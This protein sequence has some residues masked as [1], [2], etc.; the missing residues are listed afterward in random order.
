MKTSAPTCAGTTNRPPKVILDQLLTPTRSSSSQM[1][2]EPSMGAMWNAMW[3]QAELERKSP[4][5]KADDQTTSADVEKPATRFAKDQL[6][7][8]RA[9]RKARRRKESHRS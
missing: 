4:M 7:A 6:R 3:H 2:T 9:N 5:V 8:V 1:S